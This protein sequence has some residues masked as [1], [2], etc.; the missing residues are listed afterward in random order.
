MIF[1]DKMQQ[2]PLC[3]PK[4]AQE[5][6][7]DIVVLLPDHSQTG[8]RVLGDSHSLIDPALLPDR[9]HLAPLYRQQRLTVPPASIE[10]HYSDWTRL[11]RELSR[12][13]GAAPITIELNVLRQLAEAIRGANGAITVGVEDVRALPLRDE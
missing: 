7:S 4:I 3:T 10:E 11:T 2:L 6:V 1:A 12:N 5:I 9:D 13:G 8:A